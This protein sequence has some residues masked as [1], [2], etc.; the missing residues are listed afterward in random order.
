M[1]SFEQYNYFPAVRTRPAELHGIKNLSETQKDQI[2]P[3]ITLRSWPNAEGTERPVLEINQAIGNRPFLLDLTNETIKQNDA[4]KLLQSDANNF[5]KWQS[6][7]PELRQAIPIVQMAP[8]SKISHAIRQARAFEKAGLGKVGFRVS[9]SANEADRV[10]AALSA[11]DSTD[12]GLVII[13]AGYIRETMAWSIAECIKTINSIREEIP[14]A[15]ITVIS[16]SFPGSV[17]PYLDPNSSGQRGIIG[18]L[19]R[20]LH[21][22]VGG[23]EVVI[24]GDHA[25]I[26]AQVRPVTGGRYTPRI[27][28]AMAD[29]WA[30]ERRPEQNSLGYI[31]AAASLIDNY[32]EIEYDESWGAEM[33]RQ[34]RAGEIE[35]M[36]TASNWIAARVNKHVT[37]QLQISM[38]DE[39]DE[40]ELLE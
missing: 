8:T 25:S 21:Q 13:D 18:M 7:I 12:N 2:L 15:I 24:Y 22:E 34:A 40:V 11:L 1:T 29:I 39:D 26:H 35:G 3:I 23:S 6:F 30:F 5:E 4:I 31:A 19:E 27:D 17:T 9:R 36:K 32:P 33:I 14:S 28:Y 16:T 10:I 38:E 37:R 20:V